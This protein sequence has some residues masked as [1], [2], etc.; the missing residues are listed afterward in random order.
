M[1]ELLGNIRRLEQ[2]RVLIPPGAGEVDGQG[3]D[4]DLIRLAAIAADAVHDADNQEALRQV[5]PV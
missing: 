4:K 5:P 2:C 3:W 1:L